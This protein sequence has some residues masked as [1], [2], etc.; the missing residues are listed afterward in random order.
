MQAATVYLA[1]NLV[2]GKT[3]VGITRFTP[4]KRWS[5]HKTMAA[6][7]SKHWFHR[8]IA[9][10]GADNFSVVSVASCLSLDTAWRVERD[11][12]M[13]LKP[14]Y[15]QTNGGEFTAGRRE[16]SAETRARI[17]AS[18]RGRKRTPMQV[19]ANSAQAKARHA[20]NPAYKEM[21]ILALKLARSKINEKERILAVKKHHETYIW[22]D[23]SR[24][25]LS[26]S[27]MGRKYGADVLQR[28]S[29]KHKK[30]VECSSLSTVFD[31]I[32]DAAEFTG[33]YFSNI[34]MVCRGKRKTAGG[35]KFQFVNQQR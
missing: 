1:T 10:H 5:E 18:Q 25:K 21:A 16:L 29:E 12:I 23:A 3:Y 32:N 15:N 20:N 11:V 28:I 14:D 9:K 7:G 27:C 17:S 34:S 8:A 31:S 35:M 26:A 30:P 33:V 2:D 22:S 19:A 13:S 4:A 24:A 6:S